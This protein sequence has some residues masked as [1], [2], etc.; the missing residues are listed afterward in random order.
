MN[1]FI[2]QLFKHTITG[3]LYYDNVMCIFGITVTV[4]NAT[5]DCGFFCFLQTFKIFFFK[6]NIRFL[7]LAF[8][9]WHPNPN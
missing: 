8:Y 1:T 7:D 9:L 4:T 3:K 2:I 6:L 5:D